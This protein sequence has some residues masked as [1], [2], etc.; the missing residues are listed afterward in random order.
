MD[1]F[2]ICWVCFA[3]ALS[4]IIPS[5]DFVK[6]NERMHAACT[7]LDQI[8][9]RS[10]CLNLHVHEYMIVTDQQPHDSMITGM[11]TSDY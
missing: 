7:F 2:V 5:N 9:G 3:T 4:I 8:S 10:R 1:L 6:V 11:L